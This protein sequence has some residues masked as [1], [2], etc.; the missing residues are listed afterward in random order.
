MISYPSPDLVGWSAFEF[1]SIV[2][3]PRTD[4]VFVEMAATQLDRRAVCGSLAA[5]LLICW[6]CFR[7]GTDTPTLSFRSTPSPHRYLISPLLLATNTKLNLGPSLLSPFLAGKKHPSYDT[8]IDVGPYDG[9]DHTLPAFQLGY[10]VYSF[11]LSPVNQPRVIAVLTKAGLVEGTDYT[12][13]RP[14]VG[15]VPH[16]PRS[17]HSPHIYLIFAGASSTNHGVAIHTHPVCKG[18]TCL[19]VD[20]GVEGD[21]PVVR[22]DDV[23]PIAAK[24][25][26]M[27]IDA[28]GHDTY[29]LEGAQR[30]LT[31][32]RV[33]SLMLEWWPKAFQTQ[34]VMD[35]GK[36][37]L[38]QL[39]DMGTQCFDVGVHK[40]SI[41]TPERKSDVD[42]WVDNLLLIRPTAPTF[43]KGMGY[44]EDLVCM[45]KQP[46]FEARD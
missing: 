31:A 20:A 6:M 34:G 43:I 25:Y 26:L 1:E 30:L 42:G 11:E 15:T 36:A 14:I 10:D 44:W 9:S 22:V 17:I 32:N 13:H 35:G 5:L 29:V 45:C 4:H 2:T 41:V 33:R 19:E 23:V 3:L 39:Y 27:K 46:E 12:I 40:T 28:Q 24:V 16:V 21:A 18:P 38:K 37:A 7:A 8:V